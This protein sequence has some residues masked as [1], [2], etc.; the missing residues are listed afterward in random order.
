[1]N[2]RDFL[3]LSVKAG[4]LALLPMAGIGCNGGNGGQKLVLP[5]L[6]YSKDA[7]EPF[8]SAK[9]L[10]YH[11]GKH[12]LGYLNKT[13]KAIAGTK[14][15]GASLATVIEQT[16][17]KTDKT[18]IFNNA[19]QVYNH[20][21]YWNSMKPGGGGQPTGRLA[22][23]LET[24]FGGYNKF[25]ARFSKAAASHFGSGWTW[26]VTDGKALKIIST[27]NAD[28]PIAHGLKP[29]LTIDL[30]EHAYY[31]DYQNARLDYIQNYL[32]QLVNWDFATDNLG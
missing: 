26:L 6:P 4:A 12:H 16:R 9:T 11:Y 29:L 13:N 27:A 20:S 2:R 1:M 21:F 30:W 17:G 3:R 15:A 18:D 23:M 10:H 28:I 7:L 31:L 22:Q 5:T 24:A 14:Y 32:K 8:I 19:A 25:A